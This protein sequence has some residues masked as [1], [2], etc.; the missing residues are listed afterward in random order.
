MC[1][2]KYTL[3]YLEDKTK[4]NNY[5]MPVNVIRVTTLSVR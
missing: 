1:K 4:R 2:V 5:P 3:V